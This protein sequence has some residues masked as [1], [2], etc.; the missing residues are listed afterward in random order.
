MA[1]DMDRWAKAILDNLQHEGRMSNVEL[2]ETIGLSESPTL[3]RVKQLE[4][5][6]SNP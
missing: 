5:D 2:A 1:G 4:S 3:R 6:G